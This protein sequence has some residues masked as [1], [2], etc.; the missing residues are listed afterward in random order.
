[1]KTVVQQ[2]LANIPDAA[3][4]KQFISEN[5]ADEKM[6]D[7]WIAKKIHDAGDWI[8]LEKEQIINAY[9]ECWMKD[10]GNGFHKEKEAEQYYID[11]FSK[12]SMP[13]HYGGVALL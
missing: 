7:E 12:D 1:M 3:Q 6:L 8:N 13:E 10:G 2:L 9:I 5:D 4:I 11:E